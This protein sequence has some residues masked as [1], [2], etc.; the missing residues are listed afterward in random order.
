[1]P[2]MLERWNDE[3]MDGLAG[4]VHSMDV[5]LGRVEV[6]VDEGFKQM[7]KR[8]EQVD[9]RFEKFEGELREQRREMKA[10]FDGMQRLMLW[11]AVS[12]VIALIGA[13]HL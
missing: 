7:D 8:F 9:K 3:K 2:V 11:A 10:G 12:I 6:R 13:P 5:R 1:M 4:E